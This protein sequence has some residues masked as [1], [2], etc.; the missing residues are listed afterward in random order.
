MLD[1]LILNATSELAY[2]IF[3]GYSSKIDY[4][5]ETQETNSDFE[6]L[7]HMFSDSTLIFI[8]YK[9]FYLQ[10]YSFSVGTHI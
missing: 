2:R 8:P 4:L 3:D 10:Q 1:K 7:R 5:I 6:F 9:R